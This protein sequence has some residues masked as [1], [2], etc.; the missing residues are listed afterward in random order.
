MNL[1]E[2]IDARRSRRK[3]RSVPLPGDAAASLQ[4]LIDQLQQ[5]D[6]V[7]MQLVL[8]NGLAFAGL[9]RS[10]GMF[11]GVQHYVGL[12]ARRDDPTSPERLGY[13]GETVALTAVSL[14]LGTCWVGGSFDRSAC[15]FDLADNETVA[16]VITIGVVDADASLKEKMIRGAVHRRTR[17]IDEMLTCD[18]PAPDWVMDGMRAVQKA[19]SAAN[20]QPVKFTYDG[21]TVRAFVPKTDEAMMGVDFGIAK[22]HFEIGAGAG[23]WHWG[24]GAAFARDVVRPYTDCDH[25]AFAAMF[26]VCFLQDYGMPLS[27]EQ[28][29]QVCGK[30]ETAARAGVVSIDL[31]MSGPDAV[32][33]VIYQIDAPQ[34]DWCERP[35][36]GL[37]REM[38]VAPNWRK[39]GWGRRLAS[40]AEQ[41]LELRGATNI[42]LTTDDALEF[43]L[44]LGYT[45][46]NQICQRNEGLILT[47]TV[48]ATG[49]E[50]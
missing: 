25:D 33:F 47:K 46:T 40:H 3:Y 44:S 14:G 34:S 24:N 13:D 21:S 18:S 39:Q 41:A 29:T 45:N 10:Y 38:F 5:R 17:S 26:S 19:P 36:W 9:R 1:S 28:V 37:I 11:T 43:W 22:L 6:D 30:I 50:Q 23:K 2:A 8:D 16:C 12:I 15:P 32:G 35:G 48:A 31:A 42:Y 20:R 7:R 4:V 49:T 27:P